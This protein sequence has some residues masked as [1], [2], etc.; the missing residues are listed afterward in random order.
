MTRRV[1]LVTGPPCAGKTTYVRTH[2]EPGDQV[3]DQDVLGAKAMRT[4]L[5]QIHQ[6]HGTTWVIRCAPGPTARQQLVDQLGAE[7]VH[8]I[9][10]RDELIARATHRPDRRRHIAAIG[11]WVTAEAT[12]APPAHRTVH[13][14]HGAADRA[15][16][17]RPYRRAKQ[18]LQDAT[19]TCWLCGHHGARELDHEPPLSRLLDLGLDP[20]D[21][22]YHKAAHGTSCPCPTCGQACNQVKGASTRSTR[23]TCEW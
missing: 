21:P 2:A 5:A 22:Q 23:M 13:G 10:P 7:H 11:K 4:A 6:H 16:K 18:A 8:L 19:Q 17:G 3:L 1:V 12:D 15:R 20:L 14:G 9:A